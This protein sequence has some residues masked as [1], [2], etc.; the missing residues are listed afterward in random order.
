M[1]NKYSRILTIILVILVIG[2]VGLLVFFGVDTFRKQ[3]L[4]KEA[5][6]ILDG[7]DDF[8]DNGG[9]DIFV[10]EPTGDLPTLDANLMTNSLTPESNGNNQEGY[11]YKGYEVIGKIEIPKTNVEYPILKD[12]TK[13]SIEVAIAY[14]YGAYPNEVGNMVLVSHN[15]RDGR[16]FSN[17]KKLSNGDIIYITDNSGRRLKYEIYNTYVTDREDFDYAT[18]DTEGRRE[19]SLSTCTDDVKQ[20]LI[21]WAK[22]AN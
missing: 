13:N 10:D 1:N 7:Y 4:D 14:L 12:T 16:L 22:E 6:N 21:I 15:F 19:I 2:I 5:S 18:R 9:G 11:M 17:N 8:L 20:V 3:S